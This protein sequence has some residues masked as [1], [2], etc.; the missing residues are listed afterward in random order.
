M[1]NTITVKDRTIHVLIAEASGG[2]TAADFYWSCVTGSTNT[3][4]MVQSIEVWCTSG[5]TGSNLRFRD[6]G[7][8]S[9]NP[10]MARL[11]IQSDTTPVIIYF[12]PAKRCRPCFHAATS[13]YATANAPQFIINLA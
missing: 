7:V 8:T 12:N 10:I 6:G 3:S 2:S 5:T 9:T 13:T 1:A 4:L 11:E